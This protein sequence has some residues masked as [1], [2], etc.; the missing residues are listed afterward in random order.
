MYWERENN[1]SKCVNSY[2]ASNHNIEGYWLIQQCATLAIPYVCE[3]HL[4]SW[5]LTNVSIRYSSI[6]LTGNIIVSGNNNITQGRNI[7]ST[8]LQSFHFLI[9]FGDNLRT[10]TKHPLYLASGDFSILLGSKLR[11]E[12]RGRRRWSPV[13]IFLYKELCFAVNLRKNYTHTTLTSW[14]PT[15]INTPY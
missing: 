12:V 7:E 11:I 14:M 5:P 6:F 10:Y 9:F 4:F 13:N 15:L 3:G 8:G 2:L 1:K